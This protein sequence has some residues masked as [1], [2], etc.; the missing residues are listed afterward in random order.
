M[1]EQRLSAMLARRVGYSFEP[2][3]SQQGGQ[4]ATIKASGTR[5]VTGSAPKPRAAT[6]INTA[7]RLNRHERRKAAAMERERAAAR[8]ASA[9]PQLTTHNEVQHV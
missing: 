5:V 8:D 6:S 7:P 9:V 1:L 2:S 4:G 3:H